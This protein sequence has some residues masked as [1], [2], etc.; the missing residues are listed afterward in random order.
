MVYILVLNWNN[1]QDTVECLESIFQNSYPD[2]LV[3]VIDNASSDGSIEKIKEWADGNVEIESPFVTF[4][5]DNKP[6]PYIQYDRGVA[7]S[8]GSMA[9][10]RQ[11]YNSLKHGVTSPL[12][13]IQAGG[14]LG[15]AGGNNVGMKYAAKKGDASYI[16]ILNNDVVIDRDAL[17]ELVNCAERDNS[18]GLVGSKILY[19]DNPGTLQAAGGCKVR[20]FWGNPSLI[21]LNSADGARWD[22]PV[23]PDYI[24]GASLLVKSHVI[25]DIGLIDEDYFLYWEDA[26]WGMKAGRMGYKL[27][28]CPNSRVWH[29]EGGSSGKLTSYTDYYWTRNGLYFTLRFFPFFLPFVLLAYLIKYTV[30]RRGRGQ[31]LHFMAFIKGVL[32]FMKGK[33]GRADNV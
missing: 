1:W 22:N 3:I 21:G 28:Y 12:I 5:P 24:V 20:P 9:E 19:Y 8:G 25:K 16:W 6:I 17:T 14:N 32:D 11:L 31:P 15:Y 13:L 30:V 18:I 10:E 26:D 27:F 33:R 2:C 23:E 4:N 29:K 7:E